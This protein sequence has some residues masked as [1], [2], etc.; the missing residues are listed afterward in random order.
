MS[1]HLTGHSGMIDSPSKPVRNI[2]QYRLGGCAFQ[3]MQGAARELI[4][5]SQH[6]F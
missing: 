3:D 5:V 1:D 2:I 6:Y 4:G